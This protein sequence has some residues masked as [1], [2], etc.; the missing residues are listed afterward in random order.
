MT[1]M[2]DGVVM[3]GDVDT[4]RIVLAGSGI[5]GSF[6]LSPL[7]PIDNEPWPCT[8]SVLFQPDDAITLKHSSR[9]FL[10]GAVDREIVRPCLGS[11]SCDS[12][13]H[14]TE[15]SFSSLDW[16]PGDL[17]ELLSIIDHLFQHTSLLDNHPDLK[18]RLMRLRQKR[19]GA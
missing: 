19:A 5:V 15:N 2:V 14:W 11:Y 6:G 4:N 13:D 17:D 16:G 3:L 8:K 18:S 9:L 7:S 12:L 10:L 1:L